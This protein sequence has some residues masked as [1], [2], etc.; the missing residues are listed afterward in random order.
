MLLFLIFWINFL[1]F[2]L[3][4]VLVLV[5]ERLIVKL[6]I[7]DII[8]IYWFLLLENRKLLYFVKYKEKIVDSFKRIFLFF[9]EI[10][11]N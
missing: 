5:F 4:V 7:Y 2:G 3:I 8:I 11:V 9:N 6:I 10:E 1:I